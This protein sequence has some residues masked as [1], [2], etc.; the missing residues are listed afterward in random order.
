MLGT[1]NFL[2]P[3][4]VEEWKQELKATQ[5][6]IR[7]MQK[8]AATLRKNELEDAVIAANANGDKKTSKLLKQ[9]IKAEETKSH[10][11][12]DNKLNQSLLEAESCA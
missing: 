5:R 4:T 2:I 1:T 9:K 12:D 10:D 7:L 3:E 6:K 11:K 8:E